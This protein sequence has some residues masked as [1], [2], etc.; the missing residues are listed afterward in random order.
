MSLCINPTCNHQ[1]IDNLLFC[2]SCHSELLIAGRYRVTKLIGQGGFGKTYE[3]DA[4]NGKKVLKV[5][6]KNSP[7]AIELFK[8][9]ARVLSK[10]NCSGIPQCDGYFELTLQGFKGILHCLIMD[11]IEGIN[12]RQYIKQRGRPIDGSLARDWLI[13]LLK[14]LDRVHNRGI[15]HRDIKP[16]NIILDPYGKLFLI[17]FGAVKDGETLE[18]ETDLI[19]DTEG[20]TRTRAGT[21]IYTIDYTANEQKHGQAI[22]ESD[23]YALGCTFVYL[24][25]GK[26][27][28]SRDNYDFYNDRIDWEKNASNIPPQL[29][30]VINKA[31]ES[32]ASDRP[33]SCQEILDDLNQN[34]TVRNQNHS[35]RD[36]VEE[37]DK[38]VNSKAKSQNNLPKQDSKRNYVTNPVWM[39]FRLSIIAL[40]IFLFIRLDVRDDY[41]NYIYA[42]MRDYIEEFA[43][44]LF[45]NT[46]KFFS[47]DFV[48]IKIKSKNARKIYALLH[49][50]LLI[51]FALWLINQP[52]QGSELF[53]FFR[54]IFIVVPV[55]FRPKEFSRLQL[56]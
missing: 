28:K 52:S 15:L 12:L 39:I 7:K 1:N 18:D 45:L 50:F 8:R 20:V 40:F 48:L 4:P 46:F 19:T 5:L 43:F 25:T 55:S 34:Q 51:I 17:D 53:I 56:F 2:E 16:D 44:D 32:K 21:V 27:P 13:E 38:A 30:T 33:N 6:F 3:V 35:N 24:L 29:A 36:P 37:H 31:I 22:L 14:I 10:I 11:K 9:E 54:L 26:E 41:G 49:T 42:E 47:F 23:I